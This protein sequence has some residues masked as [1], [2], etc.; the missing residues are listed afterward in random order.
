M[1]LVF[2]MCS[3]LIHKTFDKYYVKQFVLC[4]AIGVSDMLNTNPKKSYYAM[5]SLLCYAIG[6]SDVLN[7]DPYNV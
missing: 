1:R 2:Q 7:T 3:I 5:R 6:I 4:Y